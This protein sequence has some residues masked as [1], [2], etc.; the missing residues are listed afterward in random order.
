MRKY[1]NI[2]SGGYDSKREA[3]RA[4]ELR[5]LE[6]AGEIAHLSEQVTFE[7]IPR[8]R[9]ADG[10]VVE[11][12]CNYVADFTYWEPAIGAAFIVEDVKGMKTRDYIIKRKLM[13]R[14][15]GIRIRE[16]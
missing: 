6:K 10:K 12:S 1:R 7:L 3:T 14:V 11:R 16:T 13:L 2:K 15:H 8:Q 5:L 9:G 4:Q